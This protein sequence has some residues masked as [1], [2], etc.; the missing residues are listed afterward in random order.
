MIAVQ[1]C[2]HL[3]LTAAEVIVVIWRLYESIPM[4]ALF[5]T[6]TRVS[7]AYP[8]LGV[9]ASRFPLLSCL[10]YVCDGLFV[11]LQGALPHFENVSHVLYYRDSR[12]VSNRF[13]N[14][15]GLYRQIDDCDCKTGRDV[16]RSCRIIQ[17]FAGIRDYPNMKQGC[18]PLEL[19]LQT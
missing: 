14:Y 15:T 17:A 13:F 1:W 5:K 12:A 6:C 9:E 7:W 3:I 11:P 4:A 10:W 18:E 2:L 19:I 16:E 8:I